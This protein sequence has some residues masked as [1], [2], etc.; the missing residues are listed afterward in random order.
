MVY[1]LPT[2]TAV[3]GYRFFV[4]LSVCFPHDIS[5]INAASITKLDIEVFY[6]KSWKSI[7]FGNKISKVKV[8]S[9]KHCRRGSMHCCECWRIQVLLCN[10]QTCWW[11]D[12]FT[13]WTRCS[14]AVH[15]LSRCLLQRRCAVFV[16]HVKFPAILLTVISQITALTTII[17]VVGVVAVGDVL[18]GG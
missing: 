11:S 13:R 1:L 2:P 16:Y 17:I 10:R 7:Y 12:G 8:E 3:A 4:C 5:K 6:D 9:Q 15:L 14:L 18:S